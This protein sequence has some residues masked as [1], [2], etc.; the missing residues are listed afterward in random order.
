MNVFLSACT[1]QAVDSEKY[2]EMITVTGKIRRVGN[3]PFTHTVITT[4]DGE[5]HLIS[6][7][8]EK[9]LRKLQYQNFQV[10]L[11]VICRKVINLQK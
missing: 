8:R 1:V 9:E 6:G 2:P 4:P 7:P 3:E 5:D 10:D 11:S